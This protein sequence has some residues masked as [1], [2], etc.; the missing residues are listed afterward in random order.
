MEKKI[1]VI[2]PTYN[3]VDTLKKCLQ[4]LSGQTYN[5]SDYGIIV[6]DDGSGDRTADYAAA[7]KKDFPVELEYLR[8]KNKGP[9]A[10]R[11]LGIKA[12]QGTIVLFIG[13][14][15]IADPR[16]LEEHAAWHVEHAGA[17]SA[18]LGYTTWSEEITI[19]PFMKWLESSGVQFS[20]DTIADKNE[21]DPER[22]FYTSNISL[23]KD[24]MTRNGLFDEDFR[25][26]AYEDMELGRRLKEKGLKLYYNKKAVGWHEHATSLDA[27]CARMIKVGESGEIFRIK[28]KQERGFTESPASPAR[29]VLRMCKFRIY[30]QLARF[31]ENRAVNE[32]VFKYIVEYYYRIG[33]RLYR[34]RNK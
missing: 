9:A 24:F 12:A 33:V 3:R 32:S 26:A 29:K 28:T 2:I 31:F 21:V 4:A 16:L 20:Y 23:K 15:I 14:D 5:R 22:F 30:Y 11:N 13:D 18:M 7:L 19:T 8:Q 17:E 10:A 1:T 34:D 27:A 6:V 25:Y